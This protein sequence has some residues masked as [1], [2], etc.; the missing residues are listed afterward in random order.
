MSVWDLMLIDWPKF[1]VASVAGLLSGLGFGIGH[2]VYDIL[3]REPW[4]KL[5]ERCRQKRS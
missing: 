1:V 3:L 4:R 5:L 2:A